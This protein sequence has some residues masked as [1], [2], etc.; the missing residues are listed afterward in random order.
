MEVA[1][2][3][4]RELGIRNGDVVEVRCSDRTL[5]APA[6]VSPGVVPGVVA[7]AAGQGHTANG[8]HADGRGVNAFSLLAAESDEHGLIMVATVD[9]RKAE[10]NS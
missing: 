5:T 2:S 6:H 8:R 3:D 9:V 1:E 7:I 10:K 4:A